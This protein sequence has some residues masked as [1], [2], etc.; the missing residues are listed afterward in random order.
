MKDNPDIR[1]I[2]VPY[3]SGHRSLR[4]GRGPEYLLENGLAE[5]L[6]SRERKVRSSTVHP[7]SD[8]LFEVATASLA[9]WAP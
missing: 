8:L 6:Q 5:A 3:D 7:G 1:I 2:A 4:M 9:W